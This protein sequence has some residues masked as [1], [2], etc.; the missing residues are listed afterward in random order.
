MRN[1]TAY[2]T[3]SL[4]SLV[5]FNFLDR[6]RMQEPKLVSIAREAAGAR[7]LGKNRYMYI[8]ATYIVNL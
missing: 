3:E 8:H 5:D 2:R 7:S 6:Y 4:V 1:C